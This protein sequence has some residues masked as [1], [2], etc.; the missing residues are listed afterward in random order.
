M[1]SC[2]LPRAVLVGCAANTPMPRGEVKTASTL[3]AELA[4]F[5]MNRVATLAMHENLEGLVRPMDTVF[6]FPPRSTAERQSV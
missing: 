4:Q 5:D 3:P 1:S 2:A 6:G